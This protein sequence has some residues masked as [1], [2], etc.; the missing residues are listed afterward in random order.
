VVAVIGT[1]VVLHLNGSLDARTVLA[2]PQTTVSAPPVPLASGTTQHSMQW[3]GVTLTWEVFVPPG[4]TAGARLPLLVMLHPAGGADNTF[5]TNTNMD[6][7]AAKYGF[8]I[9]APAGIEATWNAGACCGAARD[10]GVDDIG[11]INGMLTQVLATEPVDPNQVYAAGASNGGMLAY[12]LA[13]RLAYRFQAV[14]SAGG[15]QTLSD[16]Q[17]SDPVS[18]IEFHATADDFVPYNGGVDPKYASDLTN[19]SPTL[20]TFSEWAHFDKCAT[21][22]LAPAGKGE[23]V[24]VWYGCASGTLLEIWLRTEGGGHEWPLA[25]T[26]PVDASIT[27]A[28]SIASR[29]LVRGSAVSINPLLVPR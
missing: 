12:A 20:S 22:S 11:F 23:Q 9:A 10:A 13:C 16:C 7:Y 18:V 24:Q 29:S 15:N 19:F 2:A 17:P 4:T 25:P 1:L 26:A 14:F 6:T 28:K 27:I 8:V 3:D 5:V 21:Y